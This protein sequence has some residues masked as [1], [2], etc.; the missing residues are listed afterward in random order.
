MASNYAIIAGPALDGEP[1]EAVYPVISGEPV[2]ASA[3]PAARRTRPARPPREAD[4]SGDFIAWFS[5][6]HVARVVSSDALAPG[7][8]GPEN[9]VAVGVC[10]WAYVPPSDYAEAVHAS[11]RDRPK[12][13]RGDAAWGFIH[14]TAQRV[15]P[16][17]EPTPHVHLDAPLADPVAPSHVYEEVR[18]HTVDAQG[19]TVEDILSD[20][21]NLEMVIMELS[22]DLL[23]QIM[24][25]DPV[26]VR[27]SRL[28]TRLDQGMAL[29]RIPPRKTINSWKH[30]A[31][32][33]RQAKV[34]RRQSAA[35]PA[36]YD[37]ILLQLPAK[38]R[39]SEASEAAGTRHR[40][41]RTTDI[42]PIHLVNAVFFTFSE[43]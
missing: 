38:R 19:T 23:S 9:V 13:S 3:G 25:G 29:E 36:Q 27:S 41:N 7:V 31:G 18:S 12:A 20:T 5:K 33:K 26:V 37:D 28:G 39:R 40:G 14:Y 17:T 2:A 24:S 10:T 30:V 43:E 42:D 35:Q 1:G 11:L 22:D 21:G 16:L 32:V 8:L 4:R 34:A 6:L 15:W